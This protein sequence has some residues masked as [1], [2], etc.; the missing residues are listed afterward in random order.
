MKVFKKPAM[1]Q[2]AKLN[3]T[4]R[5]NWMRRIICTYFLSIHCPH[6]PTLRCKDEP[7]PFAQA[8]HTFVAVAL[9]SPP[10]GWQT[11]TV[12]WA[13]TFCWPNKDA[14]GARCATFCARLLCNFLKRKRVWRQGALTTSPTTKPE[15]RANKNV[16]GGSWWKMVEGCGRICGFRLVMTTWFVFGMENTFWGLYF[17]G[18][19]I[20]FLLSF[21]PLLL[22][23][24]LQLLL[25]LLFPLPVLVIRRNKSLR[26]PSSSSSSCTSCINIFVHYPCQQ[27]RTVAAKLTLKVCTIFHASTRVEMM[28]ELEWQE[29][30][31]C[32]H[33]TFEARCCAL[34]QPP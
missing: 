12:R 24:L 6:L 31:Y 5:W 9:P 33:C 13:H 21:V 19:I 25:L 10:Q 11:R 18:I 8:P 16:C 1:K 30:R 17:P 14:A 26:P 32:R 15:V 22:V 29:E 7:E 23:L 3:C 28:M 20:L 4:P 34:L 2:I 27:S